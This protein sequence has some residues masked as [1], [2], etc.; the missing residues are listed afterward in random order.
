M[1][2]KVPE[3]PV[4]CGQGAHNS[5]SPQNTPPTLRNGLP[6][7]VL[8]VICTVSVNEIQM[9]LDTPLNSEFSHYV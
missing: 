6:V 1:V 2:L 8:F 4:D 5:Q 7:N 3:K 9:L